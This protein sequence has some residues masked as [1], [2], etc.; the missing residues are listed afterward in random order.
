MESSIN[1]SSSEV[2]HRPRL[3]TERGPVPPVL[4]NEARLGQ[5]K[6]R[7]RASS[8]RSIRRDSEASPARSYEEA[9]LSK[10]TVVVQKPAPGA[11]TYD[12][13]DGAYAIEKEALDPIGARIVEVDTKTEEEFIAAARD[14]DALIGRN[15]RITAAI[16][17]SLRQ[18]K[19]IG[20]GSVGADTVDVDAATEAGI[21][22][23]NVPDVFIDEVADHTMAMF[24][25]AHRRLPLMHQMTVEGRWREGRPYFDTIP[26]LYGQTLGLISFGNVAKA[27]AR[28]A[29]AFGLHLI[30]YD[31]YVAELEMTAVGVEPVTS[32]LD[33]CRRSDF[34][35]MHAPL[36]SETRHMMSEPQFKAMKRSAIFVN[37]GRG[38][39]VDEAALIKALQDG[40]IAGA[41]VDVFETEPVDTGNPLL[42]MDNVIVTPHIASATARMAPET[43]RRLG[44]EIATVLQGRWPRSAV[45]PG[46]LP[47]TDLIRWQ[48]YP[49]GR[50]PNR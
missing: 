20:L 43:R 37:N 25:A 48:P 3:T 49:M 21:V 13:A 4:A 39:T 18:C 5:R 24:L 28:R 26:R 36:N 17:K 8:S 33:L 44:R 35:S 27:V 40:W 41:A 19:V 30:S 10:F 45:N 29:Q 46:V 12:L 11:I 7:T 47:K 50:G 31:P 38:P 23:T 1:L 34:L 22:V 32:F 15:R 14:A 6:C 9:R 2:Q 42:K 16:I